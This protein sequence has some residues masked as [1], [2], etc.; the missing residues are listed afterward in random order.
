LASSSEVARD[1][2]GN[3]YI[4]NYTRRENYFDR[5]AKQVGVS[6]F[7]RLNTMYSTQ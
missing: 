5:F 6:I 7:H 3:E 2:I 1:I 4:I